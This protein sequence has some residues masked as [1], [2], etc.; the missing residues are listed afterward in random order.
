MV[1]HGRSACASL[2]CWL[3]ASTVPLLKAKANVQSRILYFHFLYFIFNDLVTM[4]CFWRHIFQ[5]LVTMFCRLTSCISTSHDHNYGIPIDVIIQTPGVNMLSSDVMYFNISWPLLSSDVM[6]FKTW[7]QYVVFWRHIFQHLMSI[8]IIS[9]DVMYL[10]PGAN[11]FSSD[12]MYFK[13][14]WPCIICWCHYSNTWCQYLFFWCNVFQH[15]MTKYYVLTSCIS[16][17]RDHIL[18]SDVM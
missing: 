17:P 4:C 13:T 16:T 1:V 18:S 2:T 5:H 6:Y 11:M 8:Y 14:S 12:V 9:S 7:C 15:L 10:R 3:T